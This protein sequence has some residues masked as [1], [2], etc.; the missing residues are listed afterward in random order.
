M[1]QMLG[2]KYITKLT[3]NVYWQ[4]QSCCCDNGWTH[5]GS[6]AHVSSHCIH[7]SRWLQRN[8]STTHTH[9]H[10]QTQ[11][12]KLS[13]LHSINEAVSVEHQISNEQEGVI[14]WFTCQR[15]CL[16]PLRAAGPPCSQVHRCNEA[17]GRQGAPLSLWT[18]WGRLPSVAPQSS[19]GICIDINYMITSLS[20]QPPSRHWEGYIYV[21]IK[22]CNWSSL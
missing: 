21:P 9:R 1:I 10:T 15:W 7:R 13:A 5:G 11:T 20:P 18:R 12:H 22:R 2:G 8:T 16:C 3:N 19:P 4:F 6:T 14:L 17:P